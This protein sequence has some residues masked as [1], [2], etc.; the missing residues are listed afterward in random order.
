MS[1]AELQEET[2]AKVERETNNLNSLLLTKIIRG[3]PKALEAAV[4]AGVQ[5]GYFGV[6]ADEK[7]FKYIVDFAGKH[8]NPPT[9]E[10]VKENFPTF[11]QGDTN[12]PLS[13]VLE[14]WS[15][16]YV[17]WST[18]AFLRDR[19]LE[20]IKRGASPQEIA[21]ILQERAA[22]LGSLGQTNGHGSVV[23]SDT[24][25]PAV[26]KWLWES[27]IPRAALSL[28]IGDPG[29][30]KGLASTWMLSRA[31]NG[32]DGWPKVPC[33]V[34]GHEDAKDLQVGR[35]AAAGA[36]KVAFLGRSDGKL[37]RFPDDAPLLRSLIEEHKLEFVVIDPVQNHL[38]DGLNPNQDRDLRAALTP[39]QIVA[40][41]TGASI[42]IVHHMSKSSASGQ[43]LY[44]AM[45]SI[46]YSGIVRSMLAF[47]AKQH[48]EEDEDFDPDERFLFAGK[49]NYARK[50]A[51]L[52]FTIEES[53][54]EV[55]GEDER[56][57]RL[58]Y[59]GEAEGV[60]EAEV[61]GVKAMRGRG[62]PKDDGLREWIEAQIDGKTKIPS[63]DLEDAAHAA[64][65]HGSWRTI[66]NLLKE[67]YGWT[68]HKVGTRWVW[69]GR[70]SPFL[71]A[72]PGGKEDVDE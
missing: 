3:T 50:A 29:S 56:I 51:P 38:A 11:L 10:T 52:R 8:G 28:I 57:A 60:T 26:V 1:R 13:V 71:K 55:E 27:W 19:Y 4:A 14:N 33:G 63:Q 49:S 20:A 47:G 6:E 7:L 31:T 46:G 25:A 5:S 65:R 43:L 39:V 44:R 15:A 9:M 61:F 17:R 67:E 45:G 70:S 23:W 72:L 36:G 58:V 24:I 69:R 32:R 22:E 48:D 54:V 53:M 62:R 2:K 68:S 40:Q 37:M 59:Q 18:D 35:L 21:E 12:E 41:E 34:V 30:G 16:N 42:L 64:G 66:R